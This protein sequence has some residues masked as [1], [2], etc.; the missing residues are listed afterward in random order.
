MRQR[1]STERIWHPILIFLISQ[2]LC[3]TSAFGKDFIIA[4]LGDPLDIYP[5]KQ[6]AGED[7]VIRNLL[8]PPILEIRSDGR[9]SCIICK[10]VPDIELIKEN[11]TNEVQ[12]VINLELKKKLKW[13]DGTPITPQD[14]KFTLETMALADY[15]R[16]QSPILPIRRIEFDKEQKN[17]LRLILTQRRSDAFQLFAISLLP[18]QKADL[19]K[20]LQSEP[21][22]ANWWA[23]LQDPGLYYG[24]Y[25][26][27]SAGKE[28]WLLT[29]NKNSTWDNAPNESLEIRHFTKLSAIAK[30][31]SSREI[32]QT[33]IGELSWLDFLELKSL[34]PNLEDS[35][36]LQSR[37]GTTLELLLLNMRSPLLVNPQ[38]RQIL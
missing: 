30:A 34:T 19:I 25:I 1:T 20:K 24:P 2:V 21:K 37:P 26:V 10:E 9:I 8:N 36:T 17:K 29:S 38:M 3:E 7:L 6:K 16:G 27:K 33:A 14:V 13:G 15:P 12:S 31:L 28:R 22:D 18:S 23:K 35:F 5:L 32:D 11:D 4:S